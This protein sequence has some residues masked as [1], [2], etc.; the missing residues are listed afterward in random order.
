MNAASKLLHVNFGANRNI[1]RLPQWFI[2]KDTSW[3]LQLILFAEGLD[4]GFAVR[5]EEV[6]AA[7]LPGGF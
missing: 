5:V 2:C 6:F 4:V 3:I 1:A 7:L